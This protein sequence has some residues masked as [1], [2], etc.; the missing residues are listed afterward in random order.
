MP[1]IED[2]KR[3][4][5]ELTGIGRPT[6]QQLAMLV[7]ARKAN[8]LRFADDGETPNNPHFPVVLYRSPVSLRDSFDPAAIFEELFALHGWQDSWRNGMYDYLHFHTRTHE[9]LGIAK[10]TVRCEIGGADGKNL[11][12]KAGDVLILPAGTGHKRLKASTD[13]LVVGAYPTEGEYD[14]PKP[15]DI[16]H[17]QAVAAVARVPRP[18][19][20]PVYGT[21]GPLTHLWTAKQ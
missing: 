12:L 13:L 4:L 15:L 3:G 19:T 5:E 16:G 6:P 17:S 11:D 14:E 7:R 10:G 1:M 2:V 18:K 21:S 9:V 20:D 8:L